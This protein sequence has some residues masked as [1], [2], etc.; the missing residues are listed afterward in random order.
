MHLL[1]LPH[2][3]CPAYFKSGPQSLSTFELYRK[4][5]LV[6]VPDIL[7]AAGGSGLTLAVSWREDRGS[8]RDFYDPRKLQEWNTRFEEMTKQHKRNDGEWREM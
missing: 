2:Y 6:R 5:A 8:A 1:P 4:P 7:V 3:V